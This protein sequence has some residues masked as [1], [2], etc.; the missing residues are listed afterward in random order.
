MKLCALEVS[1]IL[2]VSL[3][4][5]TPGGHRRTEMESKPISIPWQRE[6]QDGV[7]QKLGDPPLLSP[8]P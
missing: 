3:V 7:R 6:V 1:H 4:A 2:G 8:L 5:K